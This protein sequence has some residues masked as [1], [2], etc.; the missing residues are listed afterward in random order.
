VP[1]LPDVP[2]AKEAGLP[3]FEVAVWH[4]VYAPKGTPKPVVDRLAKALQVALADANVKTRFAELG[5]EPVS[6][7]RATPQALGT[8]LKAEI[9]K[10]APVIKAAGTFAD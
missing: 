4:G 8:H 6:A 3:N 1:S 5:T 2:T 9:A 10:W 7:D